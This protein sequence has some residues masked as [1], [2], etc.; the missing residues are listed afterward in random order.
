LLIELSEQDVN[1]LQDN[2]LKTIASLLKKER[3]RK[4]YSQSYMASKLDMNQ[5]TYSRIESGTKRPST[6]EMT[7]IA[8]ILEMELEGLIDL[9]Q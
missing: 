3:L 2:R 4:G 9:F 6:G 7:A 5:N 1:M 8:E